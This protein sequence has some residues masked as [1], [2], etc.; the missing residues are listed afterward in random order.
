MTMTTSSSQP[1]SPESPSQPIRLLVADD[2][3][4]LR[5]GLRRLL[6]G[7]GGGFQVVAE[8]FDGSE[9]IDRTRGHAE[10]QAFAEPGAEVA[11]GRVPTLDGEALIEQEPEQ[12]QHDNGSSEQTAQERMPSHPPDSTNEID[13][14]DNEVV[15][16]EEI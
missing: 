2:H 6:E 1:A 7:D 8:A 3:A 9:A 14:G 11:G 16:E 4:V 15:G 10:R 12:Q 5:Q 13:L